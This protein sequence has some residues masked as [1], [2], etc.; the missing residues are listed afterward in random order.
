VWFE[1]FPFYVSNPCHPSE[2][3]HIIGVTRKTME[4][5]R[6][7]AVA[8]HFKFSM[9]IALLTFPQEATFTRVTAPDHTAVVSLLITVPLI[10]D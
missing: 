5:E 9:L 1:F 10:H 6:S 3:G 2:L 7:G 4:F 8:V